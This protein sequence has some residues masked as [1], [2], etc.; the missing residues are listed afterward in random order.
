MHVTRDQDHQRSPSK[1]NNETKHVDNVPKAYRSPKMPHARDAS[2]MSWSVTTN[3]GIH[4][5]M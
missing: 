1:V 5:M 4:D 3:R 2:C